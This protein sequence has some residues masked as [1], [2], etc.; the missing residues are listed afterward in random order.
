MSNQCNG[1]YVKNLNEK[2]Y[3]IKAITK[4]PAVID[5]YMY[6]YSEARNIPA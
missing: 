5:K 6:A 3:E 4:L 2:D 1:K